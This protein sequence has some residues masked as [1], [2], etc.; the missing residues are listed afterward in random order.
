MPKRINTHKVFTPKLQGD[1]SYVTFRSIPYG[2]VKEIQRQFAEV[3]EQSTETK[4]EE[5]N[6]LMESLFK[7]L[8]TEWNW[9]DDKGTDMKLPSEG[10]DIGTLNAEEVEFLSNQIVEQMGLK[11]QVTA[12]QKN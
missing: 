10:L 8:V 11:A 6:A 3:A 5:T 4:I 2:R 1:G 7:E 9:V 12:K